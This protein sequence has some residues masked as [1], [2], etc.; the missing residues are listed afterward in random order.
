MNNNLKHLYLPYTTF[1]LKTL[2]FS[3][4]ILKNKKALQQKAKGRGS[5]APPIGNVWN[6]FL[7]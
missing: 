7:G 4:N 3:H 2:L 6:F 1:I 5:Q